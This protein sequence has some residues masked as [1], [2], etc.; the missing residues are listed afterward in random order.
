MPGQVPRM[1]WR[2]L[3]HIACALPL[4]YLLLQLAEVGGLR[5]G[6][7]PQ[8]L[9][10]DFLG[11]WGLRLLLLTL[12]MTP[13]R[14]LTGK[15]WPLQFR[16]LLGLWSFAYLALHFITYFLLDRSLDLPL[17]IEDITERPFITIGFTAFML[18]LPLA[19]TST[20]G[21]RR[22]LGPRWVS[23]HRLV[24]LIAILGCWHFYW[25]VKKDVR[26]PLV[27]CA[28]LAVLLGFR[29]WRLRRRT[30]GKAHGPAPDAP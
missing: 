21:W 24:Y 28:I 27:Y 1:S 9:I 25:L 10:R 12:C 26:E 22:Q 2:L 11:E 4:V 6:P 30:S 29:L 15:P 23:L 13:L 19:A 17:I 7:N 20:A 3:A 5:L 18:M 16:R 14:S 8:L